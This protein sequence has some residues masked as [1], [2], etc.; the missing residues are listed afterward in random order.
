MNYYY[1]HQ[2]RIPDFKL[3]KP[4]GK[5]VVALKEL[6]FAYKGVVGTFANLS[7]RCKLRLKVAH[8]IECSTE[9]YAESDIILDDFE[10]T[11]LDG[12]QFE[13]YCADLLKN[14]GFQNVIV[15]KGSGDQGVDI[16]AIKDG[17][18]YAFQCKYYST[19]LGNTPVQEVYAGKVIY[20]CHVGVV[21]TNS[22]FTKGAIEAAEKTGV[23]LWDGDKI[24]SMKS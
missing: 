17:V 9:D 14:N 5:L 13:Y 8:I 19:S 16:T 21:M 7:K 15:T 23:L 20:N 2:L 24:R 3:A 6:G 11:L 4:Q 10:N 12:Y 18:R 22:T 1:I